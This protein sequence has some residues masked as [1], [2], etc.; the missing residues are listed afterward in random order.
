V[1]QQRLPADAPPLATI[2]GIG[3]FEG[4]QV[5]L[6]GYPITPKEH[7]VRLPARPP[8]PLA[9]LKRQ[10]AILRVRRDHPRLRDY[11][12][13][14]GFVLVDAPI[15]TPNACEG[16]TPSSRPTTSASPPTSP[17]AASSTT[18]PARWPSARSTASGRPSA[19]RSQDPPPPDRVLD[20]RA[21]GRLRRPRRRHGPGRGLR[22]VRRAARARAPPSE[23]EDARARRLA[24]SSRPARSRASPTTRRSRC[25][26]TR[27]RSEWGDDFGGDEE[28]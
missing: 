8:P 20:G 5:T 28:T 7:G 2:A 21:R 14:R 13:E 15:L 26:T 24:S 27:A 23:L 17:R 19:P 16:T 11:F 4:Q 10:H 22:R 6:R 18:R 12:D 9:A 1:T 3:A 25:C